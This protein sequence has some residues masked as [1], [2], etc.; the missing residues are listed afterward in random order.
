METER[1][2]LETGNTL[3]FVKPVITEVYA[4]PSQVA[5]VKETKPQGKTQR[6]EKLNKLF[7][8]IDRRNSSESK[9]NKV[10][11]ELITRYLSVFSTDDEPLKV[12]PYFLS[13]IKQEKDE[14]VYRRPY[15]IPIS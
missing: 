12:A 2:D 15:N 8:I 13:T 10:L 14:V 11:K 6:Q 7:Q 3:G 5:A 1:I 4:Y 9:E